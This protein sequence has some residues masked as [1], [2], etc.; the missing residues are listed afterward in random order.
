MQVKNLHRVSDYEWLIPRHGEMNVDALII[1]SRK[2]VES[3]DENIYEDLKNIAS[4]PGILEKLVVLPNAHPGYGF[5]T[6][7]VAVFNAKDGI[8]SIG[9]VGTDINCGIRLV[10]T[11][12][13]YQDIEKKVETLVRAFFKHIPSGDENQGKLILSRREIKELLTEGALWVIKNR[14]M[15]KEEDL[16]F[17]ESGGYVEDADPDAISEDVLKKEKLQ[18]GFIG[19][20]NHYLELQIVDEI[21]D[22]EK[23]RVFGL[24]KNQVVVSFHAGSQ[25]LSY[26]IN[27]DYQKIFSK[28]TQKRKILIKNPG[29]L[30]M[31]IN[32]PE[33]KQFLSAVNCAT[34]FAFANRQVIGHIVHQVFNEVIKDVDTNIMYDIGHNTI[35]EEVHKI[36]VSKKKVLVHRR[37]STR[38]FA[39]KMTEISKPYKVSGQPIIVGASI[40]SISYVLASREESTEKTFASTVHGTGRITTKGRSRGL[41]DFTHLNNEMKKRHVYLKARDKE[42]ILEYSPHAYKDIEEVILSITKSGLS[43]RVARLKPI[44]IIKG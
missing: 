24:F 19:S 15:G 20:G 14:G 13:I 26:Q 34:N 33:G 28:A 17:V 29:L 42:K 25:N 22:I 35:R 36:G 10:T 18:L 7:C 40:G 23:A 4:L 31:P 5:P 30:Y 27:K 1:G 2:I 41:S 44:G 37:G 8:V 9:G 3:M 38:N 32:T 11:N 6:G 16:D 12:L 39:G 21:F 43:Q